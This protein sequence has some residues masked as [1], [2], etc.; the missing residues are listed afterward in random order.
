[1][2]WV[3]AI[4]IKN[5]DVLW[6]VSVLKLSVIHPQQNFFFE[7]FI[8]SPL[9]K[10]NWKLQIEKSKMFWRRYLIQIVLPE[11]YFLDFRFLGLWTLA[12]ESW[13]IRPNIGR[14]VIFL[15]NTLL[16]LLLIQNDAVNS[17]FFPLQHILFFPNW[18]LT[19]LGQ[20]VYLNKVW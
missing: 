11:V 6:G 20:D 19:P 9:G 17:H 13:F 14:L 5:F 10:R 2:G 3:L 16:W 4:K 8:F 12:A 1:M 7:K 18:F 15:E